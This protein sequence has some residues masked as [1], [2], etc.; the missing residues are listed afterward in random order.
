VKD[1]IYQMTGKAWLA[2]VF[3]IAILGWA[4][5]TQFKAA[6]DTHGAA[7]ADLVAKKGTVTGGAEVT[8]TSKRR[9]GGRHTNHYFELDAK[10]ADGSTEKWRVEYAVGRQK[11]ESLIDEA[12]EVRVDPADKNLV[13]EVKLHGQTIV[14][15]DEIQKLMENKDKAAAA[16]ATDKMTLLVG[17]VA[18]LLGIGGLLLRRFLRTGRD[19]D[20]GMV[21]TP[22][23]GEKV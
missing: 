18:L 20:L 21:P 1:W 8:E 15:L 9:R 13:Y 22:A 23:I 7:V 6:S 16:K 14:S 19:A 10:L 4:G 5:Y 2:L 11:L 12:V 17:A 3:G